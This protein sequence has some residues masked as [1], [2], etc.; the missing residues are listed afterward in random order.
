V[1]DAPAFQQKQ[2]AFAAHIRDP[3]HVPPPAGIENRRMAIYRELFFN[4][5]EGLL[6]RS[7]PVLRDV[8][9]GDAW[10]SL[11]REF[12]ARHRAHTPYFLEVPREFVDFLAARPDDSGAYP[13]FLPEL[14]HY[15]WVELALSVA[16]ETGDR[17]GIDA[18]GDLLEG[19]PV[20]S[21]L[22]WPLSYRFPVH[23]ISKDFRPAEPGAQ[24]TCLVVYRKPDDE[25]AFMELNGL[26]AALLERIAGND[27]R[28]GRE[29]LRELGDETGYAD[30]AALLEHG[31][32]AMDELRA[33]GILLGIRRRS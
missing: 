1:A 20:K 21:A 12:M 10:R 2:R 16:G 22:A 24:P 31:R 29:L 25:L 13:P 27:D 26:T 9:G 28:P 8:L 32:K 11:V 33:A 14:A 4:N 30:P 7:F 17:G 15:E 18:G 6:R 5:L 19:V 23:R 3:D